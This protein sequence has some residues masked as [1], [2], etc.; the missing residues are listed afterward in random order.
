M[1]QLLRSFNRFFNLACLPANNTGAYIVLVFFAF[2]ANPAIAADNCNYIAGPTDAK[3]VNAAEPSAGI[4][5]AWYGN[6]TNL[7]THGVLG[8]SVEAHTLYAT[9]PGNEGCAHEITLDEYSVFEDVNPRIADVTGDGNN[10]I[11]VIE[12]HVDKGASLAVYGLANGTLAKIATTPHIGTSNRWLAPVGTADFN[13][14]GVNDV[15]YVQTPHI[16]GLLKIWSFKDQIPN[17]LVADGRYSN[18]RIGENY[19]TGGI[20]ICDN[21]PIMIL[22]N[23]QWSKTLSVTVDGDTIA[24]KVYANNVQQKTISQALQCQ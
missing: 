7:Y 4:S 11:I 3:V 18:H 20:K 23:Q 5:S 24:S 10:N 21:K 8:D 16:G 22:P 12:S 9:S 2:W 17:L 14:D 19:I 6:A 1:Q 15:A 13:S